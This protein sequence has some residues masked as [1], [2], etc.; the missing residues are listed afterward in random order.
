MTNPELYFILTPVA[1]PTTFQTI[2]VLTSPISSFTSFRTLTPTM[3]S[4]YFIT[5]TLQQVPIAPILPM[6]QTIIRNSNILVITAQFSIGILAR[7]SLTIIMPARPTSTVKGL[8]SICLRI[9][10]LELVS[11]VKTN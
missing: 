11:S 1:I 7:V 10:T 6:T 8:V 2:P 3:T 4:R 5:S 9:L